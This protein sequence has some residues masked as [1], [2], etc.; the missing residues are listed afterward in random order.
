MKKCRYCGTKLTHGGIQ[1][2]RNYFCDSACETMNTAFD[3]T[4]NQR[5]RDEQ[6]AKKATTET[7]QVITL[8]FGGVVKTPRA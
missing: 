4:T 3:E 8:P 2:G 7:S 6:E 1:V 5:I